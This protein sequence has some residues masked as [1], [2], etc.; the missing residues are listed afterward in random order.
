MVKGL[1]NS[2]CKDELDKIV[3]LSENDETNY[4]KYVK[5]KLREEKDPRDRPDWK[6]ER[7]YWLNDSPMARG[8]KFNDTAKENDWYDYN[9]I[10]LENGKR[11]DSYAP[12]VSRKATDLDDITEETYREYLKEMQDKYPAGTIIRSNKYKDELDG[13]P[14]AGKQILEIPDSNLNSPNIEAYKKIAAE[15][16]IELGFRGE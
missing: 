3:F 6:K 12:I 9:E 13:Q 10:H 16:G 5:R 8:N 4:Q 7:D 2:W 15:Y 1:R 14:L 11:L